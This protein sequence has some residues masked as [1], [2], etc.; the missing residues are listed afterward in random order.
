MPVPV[1][2]V[3]QNPW[4]RDAAAIE[5]DPYLVARRKSKAPWDPRIKY[6]FNWEEDVVYSLRG[7]RQVGKTTLL[8]DMIRNLLNRGVDAR[9]MFYYTCDLVDNP[10]ELA[11]TVSR[12]RDAIRSESAER[13]YIFLDEVS[14]VRDW[15]KGIK[16]LV[17][18]GKLRNVSVVLTG[19]HTLDLK[20]VSERL[21]GR[22]GAVVDT[23]DKILLP[24][25]FGEY[26]E[27]IN[28]ELAKVMRRLRLP[29]SWAR[30]S[31]LA[32]LGEGELTPAVQEI[33]LYGKELEALL[34]DYVITG[35]LPKVIHE[36]RKN[37]RI[38]ESVYKTYVD[39]IVGDVQ[40]W[41]R[42]ESYLRQLVGRI[43]DT[44]GNP[45]GWSTL[46]QETD[47]ASHNT[48]AEYVDALRD[49]FVL[50]YL[51]QFDLAR[52]TPAYQKPKRL[53]FHDPFFLHALR[54]WG[55]GGDPFDETEDFLRAPENVG[56]V[57]EGIAADHV[58]RWGFARS[59][60]KSLFAY[61]NVVFYWRGK[62]GREVDFVLRLN[63][64]YLP[65]E[66]K[67]QARLAKHDRFG[68]I[69]FLKSG[70]GRGGLLL[71]RSASATAKSVFTIPL[72]VFLSLI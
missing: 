29:P 57:V 20:G 26:A 63:R 46:R 22:R 70:K 68:I 65:I 25:K 60:Q 72:A 62:K 41:N 27:T 17:D 53:H 64:E 69:D 36:Y 30:Q 11:N 23:P 18:T 59:P 12:Y 61:E 35:G 1:E 55:K 10:R 2:F 37:G 31:H 56:H 15:Q 28:A 52:S 58:I 13:L 4:W 7:P 6:T 66:V 71:S 39:S 16:H 19:S 43:V 40:R 8:K 50:I 51:H 47:I 14:S 45:V 32:A 44:L 38:P 49:M 42:R 21:P 33:M 48:V 9:R 5:A 3:D 24:M 34:A 54:A 67:Y